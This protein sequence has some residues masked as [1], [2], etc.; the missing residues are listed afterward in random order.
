MVPQL[1][2]VTNSLTLYYLNVKSETSCLPW[3]IWNDGYIGSESL[4]KKKETP[5]QKQALK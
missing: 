1:Q 3:H 4:S 5:R 2:F